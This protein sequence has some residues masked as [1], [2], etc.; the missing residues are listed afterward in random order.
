MTSRILSALTFL[1]VVLAVG[2]LLN[3]Q[4]LRSRRFRAFSVERYIGGLLD[5]SM[6]LTGSLILWVVPVSDP[7][8]LR[9]A[10]VHLRACLE[11]VR[12]S[13]HF[14]SMRMREQPGPTRDRI[15]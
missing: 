2:T 11:V 8:R 6:L 14:R 3:A 7:G 4:L 1:T 9:V 15:A 10:T 12:G 13:R 5:P